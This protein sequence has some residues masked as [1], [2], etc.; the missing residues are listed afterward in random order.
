MTSGDR[1]STRMRKSELRL[2]MAMPVDTGTMTR[3]SMSKR[4]RERPVGA[5]TP[6]T[7]KRQSPMRTTSPRGL[8]APK[9]SL[10][11]FVPSTASVPPAELSVVARN[12]P[13]PI[14]SLRTS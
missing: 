2:N 5:S 1:T 7:R 12:R 14:L 4:P 10:A 8:F 3:S 9:S 11:T 13:A 6:T